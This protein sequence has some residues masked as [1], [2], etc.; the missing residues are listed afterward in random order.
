VAT[1]E[2][3]RGGCLTAYLLFFL[4]LIPVTVLYSLFVLLFA[5]SAIQ[6]TLPTIPRWY[7]LW[8]A[9][10]GIANFVS[11]FAIWKWKKWGIYSFIGLSI[12]GF[13][14][15]LSRSIGGGVLN[16]IR[17]VVLVTILLILARKVWNLLE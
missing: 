4:I 12:L 8:G 11:V 5:W 1:T 9:L 13:A 3:S 16:F 17:S 2:R 7:W 15:D 10:L 14:V 6:E